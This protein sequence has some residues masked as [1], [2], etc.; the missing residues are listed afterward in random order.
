M[1]RNGFSREEPAESRGLQVY[2]VLWSLLS[3]KIIPMGHRGRENI[4]NWEALYHSGHIIFILLTINTFLFIFW[5]LASW[6]WGGNLFSVS[7]S[8]SDPGWPLN[9]ECVLPH[10]DY[11]QH[12]HGVI[13]VM[14][15]MI[16]MEGRLLLRVVM[17]LSLLVA[18]AGM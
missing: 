9:S 17:P 16:C 7:Y 8:W 11:V 2:G 15:E 4:G 3:L 10:L 12:F 18:V 5:A 1:K 14:T 6:R 13:E